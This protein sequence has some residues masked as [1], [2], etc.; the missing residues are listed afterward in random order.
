[1]KWYRTNFPGVRYRLHPTRKHGVKFDQYFVLHYKANGRGYSEAVGWASEGITARKAA[2]YLAQLKEANRT[3]SGPQ[4]LREQREQNR[5]EREQVEKDS[6]TFEQFFQQ[7]YFPLAQA[8]KSL[9]SC[10]TESGLFRWWIAPVIGDKPLNKI[11]PLHLERIK[12]NMADAGKSPR[13]VH[14]CLAVVRQVFNLAIILN[15]CEG[16][17]PVSKVKLPTED[18]RRVRF[19]SRD[20]ADKLLQE[21]AETSPQLHDMALL[22]L[23]C[24]LRAGEI[25]NLTWTDVDLERG[26]LF[27]RDTKSGRNRT[28]FMTGA[29]KNM[30]AARKKADGTD[31][32]FVFKA[33]TGGKIEE[34]SN[35]FTKVVNRLGFNAKVTDPRD[36][37]CFHTLRHTFASWL[38]EAGVDLYTVKTLLGH[39]T[40]AMAERY[41]H[42]SQGALQQAVAKLSQSINE[43]PAGKVVALTR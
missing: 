34:I 20:E 3:G 22:S 15:L 43:I 21:L 18:N 42:L 16:P 9:R 40:L 26:T 5:L 28:A 1:M 30:L 35:A 19:L 14:Y 6:I 7:T 38:V 27:L 41:S 2:G 10:N 12:K 29:V 17:N 13:T 36:R 32:G 33:T 8:N 37:V 4:S 11:S 23:H 31:T 24:G 25:F 39:Q